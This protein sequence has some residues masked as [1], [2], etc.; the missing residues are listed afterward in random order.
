MRR[1]G[2]A[3][4]FVVGV[5]V[6][7]AASAEDPAHRTYAVPYTQAW[8]AVTRIAYGMPQWIVTAAS[9]ESGFV[10]VRKAR[11]GLS[12]PKPG[13]LVHVEP[14]GPSGTRVTLTRAAGGPLEFLNWWAAGGEFYQFFKDLDELLPLQPQP[15]LP[16]S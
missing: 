14:A 4:A 8:V 5:G 1:A 10:T 6:A 16:H 13:L 3:L 2:I 11:G 9:E 15:G 12:L 7:A